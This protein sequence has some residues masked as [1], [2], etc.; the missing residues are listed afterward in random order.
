[1]FR[2][3]PLPSGCSGRNDRRARARL[4]RPARSRIAQLGSLST[5]MTTNSQADPWDTCLTMWHCGAQAIS[6]LSQTLG[7]IRV[8]NR[9]NVP[10][11]VVPPESPASLHPGTNR[12]LMTLFVR[13]L[14]AQNYAEL[15]QQAYL[16]TVHDFCT[17]INKPVCTA[18]HLEVRS[19]LSGTG[20]RSSSLSV[21][22]HHLSALRTF[23][24]FLYLGGVTDNLAPRLVRSRP[25]PKK[26]PRVLTEVEMKHLIRAA[27]KPRECALVELFYATG[28]RLCE[29]VRIR[30][31]DI[32][33]DA[34]V[35]RVQGKGFERNVYF[36]RA[37]ERAIRTYVG[38]RKTGF[39]F[40]DD[41]GPKQGYL[42]STGKAWCARWTECPPGC[43]RRILRNKYLGAKSRMSRQEA[44]VRFR[45]F[46]ATKKLART[47]F[48]RP[49]SAAT[50]GRVIRRVSLAAGMEGIT[51]H[52]FRHS[53]A[54]H[55][56]DRGA[57]LRVIQELLGHA[58]LSTTQ[59]YT[60]VSV[61]KL[62]DAYRR[63]HPN[64]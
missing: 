26:L 47:A 37:A 5:Q 17:F 57:D 7:A 33:F 8:R 44:Q 12:E 11:P 25:T 6:R 14:I 31:E 45:E 61:T 34:R 10:R 19:F 51:S 32:N 63:Y 22:N 16:R 60:R 48:D 36:G 23:F 50:I 1:M 29:L 24:E 64:A 27:Q 52:I 54:T 62:A 30:M 40:R 20:R 43:Q 15:T 9:H 35:I 4:S 2:V 42:A 58:F 53:F 39:L 28:C 55:L 13:W 38:T 46:I 56:L 49:L 18:T 59:I 41:F 3:T 21:V